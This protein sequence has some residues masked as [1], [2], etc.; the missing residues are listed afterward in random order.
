MTIP[1]EGG[2]NPAL[3]ED[4]KVYLRI[5]R[6]VRN[7]SVN[8][9][10]EMRAGNTLWTDIA[11]FPQYWQERRPILDRIASRGTDIA[12]YAIDQHGAS[13]SDIIARHGDL[14][15]NMDAVANWIPT[16]LPA[17]IPPPVVTGTVPN[18]VTTQAFAD[19]VAIEGLALLMDA[20]A[21][22]FDAPR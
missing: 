9:A 3:D 15:T 21:P 19:P 7:F 12:N 1:I 11:L 17:N 13:A 18:I 5:A 2:V 20:V 10:A 14:M 16:N 6:D 4:L 8:K 22:L